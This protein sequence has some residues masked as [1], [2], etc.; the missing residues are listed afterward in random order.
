MFEVALKRFESPGM[1]LSGVAT[2]AFDDGRVV[3]L[4]E[5]SLFHVAL[6]FMGADQYAKK[7]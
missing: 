6:H 3:E 5:G 1:V 2:A 4:R 7:A